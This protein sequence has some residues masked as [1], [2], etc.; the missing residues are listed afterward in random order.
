MGKI[1]LAY[2]Y[3]KELGKKVAKQLKAKFSIIDVNCFPD[4]EKL[5][6]INVNVKNKEV[7]IVNSLYNPDEKI[8]DLC[9]AAGTLKELKAKSITLVAPYLCYMRQDK[10]FHPGESISSK[11]I[12]NIIN[13]LFN[14]LITIDPHLHRY[15][16]LGIIY[17]LKTTKLTANGLI[18][19]YIK[20]HYKNPIIV[21]PDAESYQWAESVARGLKANVVVCKKIRRSSRNVEVQFN[22]KIDV[23][24][25]E[26]IIVDDI[27][28]TGHTMVEAIKGIKN[29]KPKSI[30]CIAV[31]GLFVEGADKKL[32]KAGAKHIITTNTIKHVTNKIDVSKLI[33]NKL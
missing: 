24:G 31:H 8:I 11:I 7:I 33:A 25:K 19:E 29:Q 32:K 1:V 30:S 14:K 27:I 9:L 26:V 28:S 3:S 23:K 12:A 18:G 10:R 6:K 17:K 22:K 16:S 2:S 4:G 13:P 21:G 5:I 15:K 20:K